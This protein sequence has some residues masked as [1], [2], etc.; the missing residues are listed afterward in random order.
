MKI[1]KLLICTVSEELVDIRYCVG[2][3]TH[4]A[5]LIRDRIPVESFDSLQDLYSLYP[6]AEGNP[7]DKETK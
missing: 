6:H 7:F 2:S 3:P 1:T 4:V 5:S